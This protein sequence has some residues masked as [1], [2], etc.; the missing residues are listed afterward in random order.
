MGP[1]DL[2]AE[3]EI[4]RARFPDQDP[5]PLMARLRAL[6]GVDLVRHAEANLE[7]VFLHALSEAGGGHD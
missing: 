5:A 1:L 2:F 6:P 3:G 7:D 4:L